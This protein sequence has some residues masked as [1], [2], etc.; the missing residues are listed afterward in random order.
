MV[1]DCAILFLYHHYI[2][3]TNTNKANGMSKTKQ[4]A[5]LL[6]NGDL[7]GCLK[8]LKGFKIGI[9]KEEQKQ[10]GVAYECIVHPAFYS[11]RGQEWI[12]N[13]IKSGEELAKKLLTK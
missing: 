4:A 8:L 7:K 6:A 12:S 2:E 5:S 13:N 9:T 10:L 3:S 1:L 11:F